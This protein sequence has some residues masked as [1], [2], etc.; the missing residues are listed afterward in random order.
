MTMNRPRKK[1]DIL[2]QGKWYPSKEAIFKYALKVRYD[3]SHEDYLKILEKQDGKCAICGRED[4][5]YKGKIR[6][7][8]D[9]CHVTNKVRGLLCSSCNNGLGHFKDDV[10]LLQNALKYL[11]DTPPQE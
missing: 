2:K 3:L 6:L 9:H 10:T 4:N 11:N 7:A 5:G 1:E 8:V